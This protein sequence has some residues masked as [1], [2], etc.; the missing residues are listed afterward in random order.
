MKSTIQPKLSV[1]ISKELPSRESTVHNDHGD[2]SQ[3]G[4]VVTVHA[5]GVQ[6]T[7]MYR[8][9]NLQ[10]CSPQEGRIPEL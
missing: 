5:T 1:A 8:Q 7:S 2:L 9:S 3:L 6:L 10:K 4:Q